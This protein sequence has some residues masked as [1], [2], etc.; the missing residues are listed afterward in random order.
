MH[1]LRSY[2]ALPA[3]ERWLALRAIAALL[4]A[5][6]LL[7]VVGYRRVRALLDGSGVRAGTNGPD[8]GMVRRAA[9]RAARTLPRV[10]CLAQACAAEWLLRRAG[11]PCRVVLGVARPTAGGL[12]AHAWVE[13]DGIV[14]AGAAAVGR[15]VSLSAPAP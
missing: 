6:F 1:R 11:R 8:A 10:R 9:A 2:L 3:E 5:A 15:Y 7:R 12:D 14:V 4:I 13:C